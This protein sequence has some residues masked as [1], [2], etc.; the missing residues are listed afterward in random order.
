[1]MFAFGRCVDYLAYDW[2]LP[3]SEIGNSV[4]RRIIAGLNGK[5]DTP[6]V[7]VAHS[8][9]GL[10]GAK[11]IEALKGL[12]PAIHGQIRGLVAM[13]TPW[14]GSF[15][16]VQVMTGSSDELTLF[17]RLTNR[18]PE[19]IVSV[20]QTFWGLS[21]MIPGDRADLLDPR[22]YAPGP[23]ASSPFGEAQMASPGNLGMSPPANTL[24]IVC[25]RRTTVTDLRHPGNTWETE[26]GPGDGTV[27][28]WSATAGGKIE[29]VVVNEQHMTLPLDGSAIRHTIDRIGA[30]TSLEA[31]T[32][33]D[34]AALDKI[35]GAPPADRNALV[36]ALEAMDET[37]LPLG[38][39][40]SMMFLA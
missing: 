4:A 2:R 19:D 5:A 1:L 12:D 22:L 20:L 27:P 31:R 40:K 15:K 38:V 7:L 34:F 26:T 24:A 39:L 18:A 17:S 9:G 37:P 35:I 21:D 25:D 33:P 10:V 8:M 16:P 3:I 23:L 6:I 28:L 36:E 13:G 29:T 30:W 32:I 14:R 11:A